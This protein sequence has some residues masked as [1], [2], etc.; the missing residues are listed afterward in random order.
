MF[1][2]VRIY[3]TLK[4]MLQFYYSV[5]AKKNVNLFEVT[6]IETRANTIYALVKRVCYNINNFVR[7]ETVCNNTNNFVRLKTHSKIHFACTFTLKHAWNNLHTY[8][9]HCYDLREI[10][11]VQKTK[12]FCF[13]VTDCKTGIR[14]L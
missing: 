7:L 11:F 2:Y 14:T 1:S 8:K 9:K 13:S 5:H 10:Y 3:E 6:I 12:W 4:L